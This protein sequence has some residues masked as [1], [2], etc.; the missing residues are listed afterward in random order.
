MRAIE[1]RYTITATGCWEW[2]GKVRRDGYGACWSGGREMLAHRVSFAREHG[3]IPAGAV[4]CHKCDNPRCINP[5]HLFMGTQGDNLRDA[6]AKGRSFAAILHAKTHCKR[7][8]EFSPANTRHV[9]NG[10]RCRKCEAL[11]QRRC[12][13]RKRE[14]IAC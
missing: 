9:G 5:Q 11:A 14:G 10:R 4:V 6:F 2:T 3:E 8:H 7:G 12:Q 13:A 1:T